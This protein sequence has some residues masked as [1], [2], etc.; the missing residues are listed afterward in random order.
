M[1]TMRSSV[2]RFDPLAGV[3]GAWEL[4]QPMLVAR[5]YASAGTLAG[6]LYIC[7]G[8]DTGC[9]LSSAS[10]ILLNLASGLSVSSVPVQFMSL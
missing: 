5:A 1:L 9:C 7:G 8:S 2:E 4:V 6:R 10:L 3:T